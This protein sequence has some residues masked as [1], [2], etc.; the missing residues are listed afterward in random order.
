MDFGPFFLCLIERCCYYFFSLSPQNINPLLLSSAAANPTLPSPACFTLGSVFKASGQKG[1]FN[2][3]SCWECLF[4]T[5]QKCCSLNNQQLIICLLL[6]TSWDPGAVGMHWQDIPLAP[7]EQPQALTNDLGSLCLVSPN[8]R[9]ED[10]RVLI[11][12]VPLVLW[13]ST[14]C[15]S[16][17]YDLGI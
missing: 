9:R 1:L 10:T 17:G 7:R 8:A 15:F 3:I 16:L 5:Q 2:F 13:P 12:A 11:S 4:P 14:S 6:L